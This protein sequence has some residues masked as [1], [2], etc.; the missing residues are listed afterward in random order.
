MASRS[1]RSSRKRAREIDW[2]VVLEGTGIRIPADEYITPYHFV[3]MT[4]LQQ[5][6]F[7]TRMGLDSRG[8]NMLTTKLRETLASKPVPSPS[9][10]K[11]S[12]VRAILHGEIPTIPSTLRIPDV[13]SSL[14]TDA[15]LESIIDI[16]RT[17]FKR[18]SEMD[19]VVRVFLM[20]LIAV[21][22]ND[23]KI[24]VQLQ[25]T[26]N[27]N[28]DF[29]FWMK[30]GAGQVVRFIEVKR[31]EI[32]ANLAT[33]TDSTAQTLREAHILLTSNPGLSPLPFVLTN[34]EAWSFGIAAKHSDFS[35]ITLKS[36][37]NVT[38]DMASLDGWKLAIN[39][40]RA[41]LYGPWPPLAAAAQPEL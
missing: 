16:M 19:V 13:T 22:D 32:Y 17:K 40:L 14:F 23:K 38:C 18:V 20:V 2:N 25:P 21:C 28:T 3:D 1:T 34:G 15:I 7:L 31:T 26:Y 8:R 27:G 24:S 41:F 6:Y 35:K 5:E 29:I 37:H 10:M 11:W 12:D 9:A 30:N 36:V 4:A 33:E 39:N